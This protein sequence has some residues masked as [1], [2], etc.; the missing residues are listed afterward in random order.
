MVVGIGKPAGAPAPS[1]A[2]TND[3]GRHWASAA[4]TG[5][6]AGAVFGF[7]CPTSSDWASAGGPHISHVPPKSGTG[8]VVVSTTNAGA[9]W[10]RDALPQGVGNVQGISCPSSN[11]CFALAWSQES[12]VL[13]A[14]ES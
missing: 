9:T 4:G 10:R 6:P 5:L 13:L 2:V 7:S 11:M 12:M 14:Y 1:V 8:A 3:G